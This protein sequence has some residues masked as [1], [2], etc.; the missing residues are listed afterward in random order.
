MFPSFPRWSWLK[1]LLG[2]KTTPPTFDRTTLKGAQLNERETLLLCEHGR[3]PDCEA[4]LVEG[5]HGG[6]SVNYYCA[7]NTTCGSRF[8]VM[9]P[10]GVERISEAS[11]LK[12]RE[13]TASDGPYR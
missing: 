12:P 1:R 13:K 11:P 4:G 9:G 8:N 6:L 7:D 5:P 10:F 2:H 3:C